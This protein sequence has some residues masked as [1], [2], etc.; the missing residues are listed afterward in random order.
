MYKNSLIYLISSVGTILINFITLPIFTRF[1]SLEDY[2]IVALFIIFGSSLTSFLSL[3]LAQALFRFYF[4]YS[5]ENIKTL[6]SSIIYLLCTVFIITYFSV[7]LPFSVQIS[8]HLF[9]NQI[10][11]YLIQVSFLNGVLIYFFNY[12]KLLLIAE[13]KAYSASILIILHAVTNVTVSLYFIYFESL[14][15]LALI[16]GA[17][18]ANGISLLVSFV[19]NS[20]YLSLRISYNELKKAFF[21][22]YPESPGIAVGLLYNS[23]DKFMLANVS[24]MKETGSYDFGF[25]FATILKI[26]MDAFGNSWAP[27]FMGK[28]SK[29]QEKDKN[30]II[31][32]F[33]QMMYLFGLIALCITFFTEEAL[34]V[35]TTKE[36]YVAKYIVP[37]LVLYYFASTFTHMS[38]QQIYFS[39]KL[40]YNLPVSILGLTINLLLNVFLIPI[41]GAFGAAFATLI[42]ASTQIAL[43]IYI[44][45]RLL[46]INYGIKKSIFIFFAICSA[47]LSIYPIMY[48]LDDILIKIILKLLII[49]IYIAVILYMR[50]IDLKSIYNDFYKQN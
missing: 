19:I 29:G 8:L 32:K 14:T 48:Y 2:G 4:Q 30:E 36:F 42:A 18:M 10:S 45:N 49:T 20:K 35:L 37:I 34:I 3:G 38:I 44:G 7:I 46:P 31:T 50:L 43:N 17:L 39:G 41:Y 9:D 33:Y 5:L 47:L 27:L 1:L 11:S 12:N 25:R 6:F 22:S 15:Y 24:G 28:M 23:F 40:I 26:I 16:Y 13:K 21:Y